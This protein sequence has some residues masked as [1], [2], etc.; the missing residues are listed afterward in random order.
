MPTEAQTKYWQ[1]L[2]GKKQKP[3]QIEKRRLKLIGKKRTKAQ[4]KRLSIALTGIKRSIQFR[5]NQKKR[6]TGKF[7][8]NS[9]CWKGDGV[10]YR[11]IHFRIERMLGKPTTCKNCGKTG[12]TGKKI[13][14]ANKD[15]K[16]KLKLTDWI[17]LCKQC[18]EAFDAGKISI[19]NY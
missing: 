15:H 19:K 9:T 6:M 13:E 10:G 17:R 12:L 18:H 14:W 11:A 7:G 8:E 4:Q 2:I 1:S 16:Y 5:L 3:E